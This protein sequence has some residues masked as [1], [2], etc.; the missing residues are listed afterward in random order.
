MCTPFTVS[1]ISHVPSIRPPYFKNGDFSLAAD[2]S[3]QNAITSFWSMVSTNPGAQAAGTPPPKAIKDWTCS[4]G[5]DMTYAV[6]IQ[7]EDVRGS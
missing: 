6:R 7:G 3:N 4:G 5:G 1:T 2:G